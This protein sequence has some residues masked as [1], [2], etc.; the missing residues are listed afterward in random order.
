MTVTEATKPRRTRRILVPLATLCAAGALM[1]GS[2]ANFL[3]DSTNP[4]N[5]Y[6][7]G[8]LTQS[9][10]KAGTA[11]FAVNNLKPGD[12]VNGEVTITNTGTLPAV[13]S[14]TETAS[15]LF[16]DP[17]NLQMVVTHGATEIYRGTFGGLTTKN[18]G[19]FNAGEARTYRFS[20][21]LKSSATNAEQGKT[22]TATYV[23]NAVQT[24]NEVIEQ[25]ADVVITVPA[26]AN[27]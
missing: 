13:F 3:S 1:V 18:L 9:N 14:V 24:D 12:T 11:I 8:T 21:T 22:A 7:S 16:A 27:A 19:R 23:W 26:K 5:I 6:A 2:G 4:A 25:P 10:S 15:N 17:T 20:T